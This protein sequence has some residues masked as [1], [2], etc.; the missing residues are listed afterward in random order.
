MTRRKRWLIYGGIACVIVVA[1]SI[2]LLN[3]LSP[4]PVIQ[5]PPAEANRVVHPAGFSI[6]KP[7]RTRAL[8][9]A[10][11]SISDDQITILPDGGR[12]RYMPVLSA[13]HFRESPD[14]SKLQHDGFVAGA[15]QGQ[16]A[17]IFRGP[18]GEYI[19][20]RVII[21]RGSE[22]YEVALHI[23]GG[24]VSP[25]SIPSPDWQRYLETFGA[26]SPTASTHR[27]NGAE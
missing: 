3:T 27:S 10:A 4:Y 12:S 9:E 13:S 26:A 1:Q 19:A 15:F 7:G 14:L 17:L 2:L 16:S 8:V 23:P 24:D 6:V 11:S 22:W 5:T 21:S 25:E 20:Y 18:S